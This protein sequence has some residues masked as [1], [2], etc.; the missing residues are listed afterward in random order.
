MSRLFFRGK[1]SPSQFVG[2]EEL[3]IQQR[4]HQRDLMR[5]ETGRID[6]EAQ[7][8]YLD[9]FGQETPFLLG[10][11]LRLLVATLPGEEPVILAQ[12][13][14]FAKIHF[15]RLMQPSD[16]IHRPLL[17]AGHRGVFSIGP[18][19]HENVSALKTIP[20]LAEKSKIVHVKIAGDRKSG[21]GG[22]RAHGYWV[23]RLG[24]PGGGR[25]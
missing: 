3:G 23:R 17:Q 6:D 15:A 2:G 11:N 8:A 25:G 12:P 24:Q 10:E 19:P 5:A 18:I 7:D 9:R 14:G 13:F 16:D 20:E 21:A 22:T 1:R 4:R